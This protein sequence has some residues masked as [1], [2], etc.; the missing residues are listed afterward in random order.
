MCTRLH[1]TLSE[2]VEVASHPLGESA[3]WGLLQ[4]STIAC[5]NGSGSGT[6]TGIY[7]IVLRAP[8]LLYYMHVRT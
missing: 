7:D 4:L 5:Q 1:V 6:A 8:P 2:V 3:L